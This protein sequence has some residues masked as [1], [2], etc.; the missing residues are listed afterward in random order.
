MQAWWTGGGPGVIVSFE[1][2]MCGYFDDL[3]M[4]DGVDAAVREGWMSAAEA[5]ATR[6][7]H[8]RAESYQAPSNAPD[9]FVL[10]DPAWRD[11]VEAARRAW[12]GL[13]AV[14]DDSEALAEMDALEV[15]W[16]RV[17]PANEQQEPTSRDQRNCEG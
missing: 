9:A 13:R 16:G 6:A 14:V 7:F 11:V 15:R 3:A 8:W 17:A 5:Q 2:L 1:E 10:A 4:S 12:V